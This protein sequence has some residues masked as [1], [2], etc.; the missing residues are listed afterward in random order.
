MDTLALCAFADEA[1][2]SL[3]EQIKALHENQI[4]MLE[5]RGVDG[6]NITALSIDEAK[7]LS[8]RLQQEDIRVWSIGSPCGKIGIR[9][10]FAPHLDLFRHTL[11]LAETLGAHCVRIFSFFVNDLSPEECRDEVL[12]RL[13]LMA[14]AAQGSNVLVCHE[15]EK[16]VYGDTAARCA[17]IHRALPSLKAVFDP[18]NFLQCSQ[19]TLEAFDR[20]S[21]DIAYFHVKD[22][23]KNGEIVP[24]GQGDG[25]LPSLSEDIATRAVRC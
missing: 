3:Q 10:P 25:H 8:Q 16:G 23:A 2:A 24:A 21:P 7:Q 1:G 5:I 22:C 4:P 19:D 14:E 13:S 11:E 15:N 18:A 9:E 20:L 12:E 17:D 6:R